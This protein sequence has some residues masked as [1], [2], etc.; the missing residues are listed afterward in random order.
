MKALAITALA[1]GLSTGAARADCRDS[2]VVN[3]ELYTT[4]D[5]GTGGITRFFDDGHTESTSFARDG[6]FQARVYRN[7]AGK[8]DRIDAY[9][10][11]VDPRNGQ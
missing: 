4:C 9:P 1:I 5:D 6:S 10:D 8:I 2:A 7:K 3:G 11:P